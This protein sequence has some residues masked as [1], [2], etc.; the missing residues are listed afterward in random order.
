MLSTE[1]RDVFTRSGNDIGNIESMKLNFTDP[2]PVRKPYRKIPAQ[3]YSEVKD[4]I[5]NL[6]TS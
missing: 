3:I 6:L 5:E 4:Y 1:E 2:I